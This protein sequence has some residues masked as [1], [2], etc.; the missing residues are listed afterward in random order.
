MKQPAQAQQTVRSPAEVRED[1]ERHGVSIS[2]WARD[3]GFDESLV[4]AVLLERAKGRYGKAHEIAV[5][6]GLKPDPGK[7]PKFL[8]E[9][10][11]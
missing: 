1:F 2:K 4:R 6:L 3:R 11:S 9:A 8:K 5:A 7:P 10:R